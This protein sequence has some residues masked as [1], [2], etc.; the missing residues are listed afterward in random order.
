MKRDDRY[1]WGAKGRFTTSVNV[2]TEWGF[3]VVVFFLFLN[4][5]LLQN[6]HALAFFKAP[7]TLERSR[8]AAKHFCDAFIS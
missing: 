7:F 5:L 1:N 3:Q 8:I 6:L 2:I 4:G